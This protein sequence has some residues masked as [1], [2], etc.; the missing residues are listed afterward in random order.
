MNV[1]D[2]LYLVFIDNELRGVIEG[3]PNT[4]YENGICVFLIVIL[5]FWLSY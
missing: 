5:F 4:P 2:F 3:P 1:V